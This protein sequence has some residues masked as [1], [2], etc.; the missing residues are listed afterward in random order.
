MRLDYTFH[1]RVPQFL[2]DA[3]RKEAAKGCERPSSY[4]RR[5]LAREV[6]GQPLNTEAINA[7]QD[8]QSGQAAQD[9]A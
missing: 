4:I 6:L 3:V 8:T 9:S 2:A 1:F 5:L 7:T